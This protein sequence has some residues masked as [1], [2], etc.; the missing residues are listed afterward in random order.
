M[1]MMHKLLFALLCCCLC[2]NAFATEPAPAGPQP[3]VASGSRET[4]VYDVRAFE[5]VGDGKTLDTG[6]I[7]RAID[8]CHAA[9]GGRVLVQGG[10]YLT[11]S[12]RLRSNVVL[13]VEAG[14][15][16]LGSPRIGD[17]G[18]ATQPVNWHQRFASMGLASDRCLVYGEDAENVAIEG[19]GTID[20]QGGRKRNLFPNRE[21]PEHQRPMLVRFQNCRKV[22]LRDITL[23]DP[24]FFS[25]FFVHCRDILIDG[26][27]VRSR[28]TG[29][30]DGLDFDG[31]ENVRIVN[32]DLDCG[33][34]AISPK[35]LH[36]DWPNRNFTITNCRMSS[37]WAAIR[38]G[39]E[40]RGNMCRFA[41]SN[42]VF[43]DCRDGFK[44]Q[45]C[46]GAMMEDIVASNIV[47]RDVNRP[48]FI[49]LNRFSFSNREISCRPPAGGL[50]NLQFDNIRAVARRGDPASLFDMSCMAIVGLPGHCVENVT[51]ANAHL[52]FPGGGTAEQA[53]RMDVE[54][55]YDFSTL[56][57]EARHFE[58]ELPSSSVYLRHV[59]GITLSN[60]RVAVEKPDQ[61]PFVAGDDLNRVDL[62]NVSGT[63]PGKVPGLAK[64]ADAQEVTSQNCRVRAEGGQ[65]SPI[66]VPLTAEETGRLAEYRRRAAALDAEMQ[67]AAALVDAAEKKAEP[68]LVLPLEWSFRPDPRDEGEKGRWFAREPG[69]QWKKLGVDR[70]WTAQRYSDF[71]GRG[72]Y[73][74]A[75]TAP[76]F[77][78]GKRLYLYFGAVRGMCRVWVDGKPA[79]RRDIPPRYTERFPLAVD[80]TDLIRA[81]TRHRVAVQVTKD[82]GEAGLWRPVELRG[83]K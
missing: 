77:G 51:L 41:I 5:A 66:L 49:T 43:I 42:C 30:G 6:A 19:P 18:I 80:V 60:V 71:H 4:G 14:A 79:G 61:R 44:I 23:V 65:G 55:L 12:I 7:Q 10:V 9:G 53:G 39:P 33:D 76:A 3:P 36:P 16:L 74:V 15:T 17:Y 75:F 82:S 48:M 45:S 38:I 24:A 70:P 59:R 57:P 21:D 27:T 29:S 13:H 28:H 25:T 73:S 46:E 58:G 83:S 56:W 62:L 34:D 37:S 8:A 54:E 26:V 22:S 40:S 35:T 1:A 31:C 72:W 63:A 78:G 67:E 69:P 2:G 81:S 11:G 52:T 50:R 64:L 68:L 20:G 32:C 47:M